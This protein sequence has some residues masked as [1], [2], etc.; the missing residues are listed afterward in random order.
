MEVLLLL[1]TRTI[2]SFCNKKLNP[3]GKWNFSGGLM[4]LGESTVETA[5]REVLE[6]TN[7]IVEDLKLLGVYS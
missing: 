7:L 3:K 4:E 6:E 5:K 2:K 1:E